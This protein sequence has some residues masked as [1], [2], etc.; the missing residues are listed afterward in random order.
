MS[1]NVCKRRRHQ[2]ASSPSTCCFCYPLLAL[3]AAER[4]AAER[5]AAERGAAE[6][7]AAERGSAITVPL[8]LMAS[9]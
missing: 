3:C 9:T 5:G 8:Q 1:V 2:I 4:G 6:R 7:G